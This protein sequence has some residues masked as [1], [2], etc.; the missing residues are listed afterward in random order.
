MEIE[1]LLPK[2]GDM[3][4]RFR[5]FLLAAIVTV[6][7]YEFAFAQK[8][9]FTKDLSIKSNDNDEKTSFLGA[10]GVEADSKGNIYVLASKECRI[11]IYNPKGEYIRTIGRK[12]QGPGELEMATNIVVDDA[13]NV[14]VF[15]MGKSAFLEFDPQGRF[16]RNLSTKGKLAGFSERVVIDKSGNFIVGADPIGGTFKITRYDKKFDRAEDLYVKTGIVTLI[17]KPGGVMTQAPFPPEVVWAMDRQE[18]LYVC[19]NKTCDIEVYSP[20]RKLVRTISRKVDPE[21]ITKAE[22]DD[23]I[24][25][26]RGLLTADD[27][28]KVKPA[29]R[30]L[31]IVDNHLFVRLKRI[32][33]TYQYYVFDGQG[34]FVEEIK[35]DFQPWVAKAGYVYSFTS[36]SDFSE[37]EVTRLK[38][39]FK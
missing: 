38:V 33:E 7:G 19:F 39:S 9:E 15:D 11:Q 23:E 18:N 37:W 32:D 35:L 34:N 24:K 29:V 6:W 25:H 10:S 26:S 8:V 20:D 14:Y 5:F 17:R 36:N 12:G 21:E 22:I 31:F 1:C 16:V 28:P 30:R 4:K 2:G 27:F 13:D 3:Y